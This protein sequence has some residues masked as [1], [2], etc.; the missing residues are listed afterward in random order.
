MINRVVRPDNHLDKP[1]VLC[2]PE[3]KCKNGNK[4]HISAD[5]RNPIGLLYDRTRLYSS[6]HVVF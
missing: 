1:E 2:E 4:I 3:Q 6:A 5:A